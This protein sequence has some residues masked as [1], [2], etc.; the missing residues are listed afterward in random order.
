MNSTR[1]FIIEKYLSKKKNHIFSVHLPRLAQDYG[2]CFV[3]TDVEARKIVELSYQTQPFDLEE[4]ELLLVPIIDHRLPL[5]L[6][7]EIRQ[8]EQE[9]LFE[10][11]RYYS[12]LTERQIIITKNPKKNT[13]SQQFERTFRSLKNLLRQQLKPG[14]RE[15]EP[16]PLLTER[17]VFKTIKAGLMKAKKLYND[18]LHKALHG[19]TPNQLEEKL[20]LRDPGTEKREEEGA[21][22]E[23][24]PAKIKEEVGLEE[25]VSN[26]S[27]QLIPVESLLKKTKSVD[28]L[29]SVPRSK[30]DISPY[31]AEVENN[32]GGN[33]RLYFFHIINKESRKLDHV[34]AQTDDIKAQTGDIKA[35]TD[36]IK[37]QNKELLD[38]NMELENTLAFMKAELEIMK[39]TRLQVQNR[40]MKRQNAKK[41]PLRDNLLPDEFQSILDSVKLSGFVPSR[42]KTALILLYY[43]GLRVSNLL[44]LSVHNIRELMEKGKTC[45]SLIKG[46]NPRHVINLSKDAR[47]LVKKYSENFRQ[48]M[49]DKNDNDP[50]YTTQIEL[51]KAINRSSFDDELNKVLKI[52]SVRLNKNIRTHSFRATIITDLLETTPIQVVKDM[53]GHRNIKSTVQYNRHTLSEEQMTN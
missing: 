40:K 3:V 47:G 34:I 30:G 38:K 19:M 15:G 52:A 14:W 1:N 45:I 32:F 41:Q 50:F 7:I 18:K 35:Q 42:K 36:D 12:F 43:T 5:V 2:Y 26:D 21:S 13:E 16:D 28:N 11:K 37:A 51:K 20:F 49:L 27:N 31:D 4:I 10:G 22:T 25:E 46:G 39:E 53:I 29:A 33:W 44:L 8:S 17:F 48:L 9:T 23:E 6:Q 24:A